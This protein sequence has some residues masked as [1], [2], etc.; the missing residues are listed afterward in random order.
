MPP[1]RPT[2]R[3]RSN[4]DAGPDIVDERDTTPPPITHVPTTP[5]PTPAGDHEITEVLDPLLMMPAPAQGAL[6]RRA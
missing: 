1:T 2:N 3:R 5:A 6:A 4:F